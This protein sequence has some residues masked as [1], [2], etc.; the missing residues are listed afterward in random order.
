MS[1]TKSKSGPYAPSSSIL[2]IVSRYRSRG[3]PLPVTAE[4]LARVGIPE[5]LVPRTLQ[6]LQTLDLIDNVGAPTEIFKGLQLAPEAEY[7]E[8]MAAWIKGAYA[9]IFLVADPSKDDI[10]A[11]KDAFRG[12]QP[13]GQIDRMVSLFQAL[14][15]AAGIT[16]IKQAPAQ[17]G[18]APRLWRR[19]IVPQPAKRPPQPVPPTV[20]P[21]SPQSQHSLPPALA[22]LLQSLPIASSGWTATERDKFLTAFKVIL[23]YCIPVVKKHTESVDDA[24]DADAA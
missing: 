16:P 19:P 17:Q 6:A 13:H 14:C 1:V 9:E 23:D 12:F 3:L 24:N 21:P 18:S 5:S 20:Q 2:E 8:R 22:G 7:R 4:V 10:T 15:A 11:V